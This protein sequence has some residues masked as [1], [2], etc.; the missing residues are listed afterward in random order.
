M[1]TLTNEVFNATSTYVNGSEDDIQLN[2]VSADERLEMV[3]IPPGRFLGLTDLPS[4]RRVDYLLVYTAFTS[5]VLLSNLVKGLGF[6]AFS[7]KICNNIHQAMV[8]SLVRAKC[9]FFTLNSAGTILNLYS[10]DL[11]ILDEALPFA[12]FN[13]L[14]IFLQIGTVIFLLVWA[15]WYT[16]FL[17]VFFLVSLWYVRKFYVSA[18]RDLK[19]TEAEGKIGLQWIYNQLID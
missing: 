4:L 13:M 10:H 16:C 5:L 15:N 19:R 2:D 1:L 8:H 9:S 14:T 7:M 3:L 12:F 11:N 17:V 6:F 18:S